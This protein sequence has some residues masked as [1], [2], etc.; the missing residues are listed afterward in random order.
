MRKVTPFLTFRANAEEAINFYVSLFNNSQI[1]SIVRY[2]EDGGMLPKGSVLHASF[3]LDGQPFMAMDG[4]DG[5][6][7]EQGFS[8]YVDCETQEEIDRLWDALRQGG[9]EEMCGWIKDRFGIS[10]QIIPSVLGR[11]MSDPDPVKAGRVT[12]AMLKMQKLDIKTLQEA[13]ENAE[14]VA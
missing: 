4:G 8:I 3:E 11:Y 5:F 14:P 13:Y 10:W 6:Q 2:E 12:Q 7:F 9:G 1:H